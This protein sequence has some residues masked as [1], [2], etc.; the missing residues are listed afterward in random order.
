[1]RGRFYQGN[2]EEL[3]SI[4]PIET[5]D[6][7]YSFGVI[8]HTPQPAAVIESVR[9]YLGPSSE[10]RLMMYAKRSWKNIMIDAGFDQPE[11]QSGCPV[12]HTYTPEE[13]TGLLQGYSI[14]ELRQEHIFPYVIEKYVAYEYEL[15]PWFREMPPEMFRALE[16]SLGWHTLVR[17]RVDR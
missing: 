14:L 12:A 1:M 9:R 2:A 4:V 17:C 16:Q 5:F 7:V 15:Q 8:H 3:L 11:A 13:L 6:L 10:F